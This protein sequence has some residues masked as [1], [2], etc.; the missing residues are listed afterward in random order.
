MLLLLRFFYVFS[1]F[2]SK[3]KSR[4]FSRIVAVFRTFSRT[5]GPTSTMY[6]VVIRYAIDGRVIEA[7]VASRPTASRPTASA[8]S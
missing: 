2:F 4:D 5:M 1:V 6:S 3:S 8:S 7:N